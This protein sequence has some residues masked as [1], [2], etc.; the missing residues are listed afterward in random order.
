MEFVPVCS[1]DRPL[2]FS[3]LD[4]LAS[5]AISGGCPQ[6]ISATS[7]VPFGRQARLRA[8]LPVLPGLVLDSSKDPALALVQFRRTAKARGDVNL[9]AGLRVV[10]NALV[11]GN[12]CRFDDHWVKRGR[13]WVRSERPGP[14]NC[15]PIAASVTAGS[16]LLLALLD[17]LVS[18]R[19]ERIAK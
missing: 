18:D 8:R 1:P 7:Y 19:V 4:V 14:W 10:V 5:A 16:R 12:F 9:A 15:L 3:A 2:W 11:Y 6:I 17:R 13:S